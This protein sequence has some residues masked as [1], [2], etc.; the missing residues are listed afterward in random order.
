MTH[1]AAQARP[2]AEATLE[3]AQAARALLDR[4]EALA[5]ETVV[6][7][8]R[9]ATKRLRAAWR[10]VAPTAGRNRAKH[11][12]HALSAIA[13][14]LS[15]ARDLAVWTGLT[16]RLAAAQTAD[17][18]TLLALVRLHACLRQRRAAVHPLPT[19]SGLLESIRLEF[20]SEI[21]AWQALA[22]QPGIP[23]R[24]VLRR[25]LRRSFR[26]ARRDAR[27]ATH[28]LT[29]ELWHD[30]RKTVKRLRY[31]REFA[32]GAGAC[33]PGKLDERVR[34]LGSRLGELHDLATLANFADSLVAAGDWAAADHRLVRA[35]I[36]AAE[37][38]LVQCCRR[39]AKKTFKRMRPGF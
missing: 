38:N 22:R 26:R 6:H 10:L 15:R 20:I 39:L 16:E 37:S 7:E 25:E 12:R 32:A 36:A 28:S 9:V 4:T 31:Q 5:D 34:R 18:P 29:A 24:R 33:Q 14:R 23:R 1:S 21:A 35:A 3:V 27:K 11:R 8:L 2:L 17:Q 30:W 13:A 19:D